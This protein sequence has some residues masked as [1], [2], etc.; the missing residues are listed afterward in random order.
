MLVL[1]L[2]PLQVVRVDKQVRPISV[3]GDTAAGQVTSHLIRMGYKPITSERG[4]GWAAAC[5]NVFIAC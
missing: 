4:G 2:L 1:P 3:A 5:N